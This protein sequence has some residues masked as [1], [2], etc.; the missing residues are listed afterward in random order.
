MLPT[1]V[2]LTTVQTSRYDEVKDKKDERDPQLRKV[3]LFGR[4]FTSTVSSTMVSF[5]E[6]LVLSEH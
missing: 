3:F 6:P 5:N 4:L 2:I 1:S